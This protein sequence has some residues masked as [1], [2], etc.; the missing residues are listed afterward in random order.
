M[1]ASVYDMYIR[2][3]VFKEKLHTSLCISVELTLCYQMFGYKTEI[4]NK[5]LLQL[6]ENTNEASYFYVDLNINLYLSPI[7]VHKV[8]FIQYI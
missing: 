1:T 2:I 7:I 4:E 8:Q 5:G 6:I 3:I